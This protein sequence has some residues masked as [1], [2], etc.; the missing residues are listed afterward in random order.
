MR[1]AGAVEQRPRY[2]FQPPAN[3]M[4]V[5]N[6]VIQWAEPC[7]LFYQYNPK[8]LGNPLI[9]AFP[10]GLAA[11]V[12]GNDARTVGPC[13]PVTS[14]DPSFPLMDHYEPGERTA[15]GRS[16]VTNGAFCRDLSGLS[17]RSTLTDATK[18]VDAT[19]SSAKWPNNEGIVVAPSRS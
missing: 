4:N 12:G 15:E 11:V 17:G 19:A 16:L 3:W 2:H 8:C 7:H 18:Q 14:F 6:G 10:D 5:P 9:A 13:L 1:V